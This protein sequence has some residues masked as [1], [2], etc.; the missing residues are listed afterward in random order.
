MNYI[1]NLFS[2]SGTR[3]RLSFL[4]ATIVITLSIFV[5][6]FGYMV[7]TPITATGLL[8]GY[9]LILF[10]M[11]IAVIPVIVQRLRA[12]LGDNTFYIIIVFM[13]MMIIP[14]LNLLLFIWPSK[15]SNNKE[16]I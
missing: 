1:A 12:M 14:F 3:D 2:L 16:T 8:W 15:K 11:V 4:G 10:V 7:F 5:L 6:G 13:L 9:L